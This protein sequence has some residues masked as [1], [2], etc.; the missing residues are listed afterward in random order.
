M[1]HN[2][3]T[4]L[5]RTLYVQAVLRRPISTALELLWVALFFYLTLQNEGPPQPLS[6]ESVRQDADDILVPEM[7]GHVLFGPGGSGNEKLVRA[8]MA[9]IEKHRKNDS[10][11]DGGPSAKKP[12]RS[13][14][15]TY[16]PINQ[17]D[18][19]AN[20]CVQFVTKFGTF[21]SDFIS[22]QKKMGKNP[23]DSAISL[24]YTRNPLC[25]SLGGQAD[26]DVNLT[27]TVYAPT[28]RFSSGNPALDRAYD[29][30]VLGWAIKYEYIIE[31]AHTELRR[32]AANA[33]GSKL[34]M[35]VESLPG[36]AFDGLTV[37]YLGPLFSGVY[38]AFL[39][40]LLR[41]IGAI[42]YEFS[43]GLAEHQGIMGLSSGQFFVGHFLT[44]ITFAV[45]EGASVI[46]VMYIR[47][48]KDSGTP[49]AHDIDPSL[50]AASF[51]MFHIGHTL[52][53][54]ML[55]WVF[56]EGWTGQ[57]VGILTTIVAPFFIEWGQKLVTVPEY[58]LA[59][60]GTKIR[61]GVL[62][63]TGTASVLRI[64]FLAR[65]YE[66]RA[67]WSLVARRVLERDNVTILELWAVMLASD[68]AMMLLAWYLSKVLPWSTNN[69]QNPFFFLMASYWNPSAVDITAN[70]SAAE[71]DP[72][73]FEQLPPS[74]RPLIITQDL[75]KVYGKKTALNG[76]DFV[77]Y[78][79]NVTVLLG[80]NGAGKTTLMSILT[81][82]CPQSMR[83]CHRAWMV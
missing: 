29:D 15:V 21:M 2:V 55:A 62:P 6:E 10:E 77:V 69:P 70:V 49:Y 14:E 42:E 47:E 8:A 81:G 18:K 43:S 51:G 78:E 72:R 66:G 16:I 12:L 33:A 32:E 36:W 76:L 71:K 59:P 48:L 57:L 1:G 19:V 53:A 9:Y 24:M 7:P 73:R 37:N 54:M 26:G 27:Y 31:Q 44:A 22:S 75:V 5:W 17:A 40:P 52:F 68:A 34:Q 3:A 80:H 13:E 39:V 28:K 83:R 61:S 60:R 82:K 56:P 45:F 63:H 23:S 20:S 65:D 67:G 46:A 25:I 74:R 64:I 35:K 11:K 50:L 41:R 4:F 38:I 30:G 79:S 58:I